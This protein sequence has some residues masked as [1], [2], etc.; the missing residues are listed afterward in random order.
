LF[1]GKHLI[2]RSGGKFRLY[3]IAGGEPEVLEGIAD[4]EAIGGATEDGETLYVTTQNEFPGK[5]YKLNR[6]TGQ[7]QLIREVMPADR[8]GLRG[9][10][11]PQFTPDGK[12]YAYSTQQALGELHL[13]EGLK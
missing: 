4:T 6:R 12:T 13:V 7:R 3:P 10:I 9:Y 5:V 8:A 1:A 2:A 11:R